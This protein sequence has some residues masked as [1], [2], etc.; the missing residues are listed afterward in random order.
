MEKI[1]IKNF[2]AI[3]NTKSVEIP[4]KNLLLMIGGNASGKSTVATW[5]YFFKSVK[6]EIFDLVLKEELSKSNFYYKVKEKLKKYLMTL[7]GRANSSFTVTYYYKKY[8]IEIGQDGGYD[9]RFPDSLPNHLERL[10]LTF[11]NNL[12]QID[13]DSDPNFRQKE[14]QIAIRIFYDG[15]NQLFGSEEY[16]YFLPNRNITVSLENRLLPIYAQLE[17]ALN[18]GKDEY[19]SANDLLLLRLINYLDKTL[20]PHIKVLLCFIFQIPYL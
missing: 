16:L 11:R 13:Q 2:K 18:T 5:V 20:I 1:L 12:L 9:V 4:V 3:K 8:R 6:D 15:L 19:V 17:N 7:F 14:R 10:S